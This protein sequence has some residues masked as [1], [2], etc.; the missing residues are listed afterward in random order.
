MGPRPVKF[1]SGQYRRLYR[2]RKAVSLLVL[3]AV[4]SL[5]IVADRLGLLGWR[6]LP[7]L[8]KYDRASFAVVKVIDGDTLDLDCSDGRHETTRVRLWGVDTPETVKPDTPPQHFGR[9][10]S[11]YTRELIIG[12]TVRLELDDRRTRDKYDRLLA[13]LYLPDGRMLNRVLVAEGYAYADTRYDHMYY[14]EFLRLQSMARKAGLGLWR[15]AR[16]KDLP[17]YLQ[18]R[19]RIGD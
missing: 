11:E 6:D 2:R 9:E 10:S 14:A 5:V 8:Q 13:Y 16:Q 1:S 12:K 19:I 3:A 7:D 4:L 18:D 17:F 15:A